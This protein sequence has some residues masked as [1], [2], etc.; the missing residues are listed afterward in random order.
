MFVYVSGGW[1]IVSNEYAMLNEEDFWNE[2][3][4]ESYDIDELEENL[5]S[6]LEKELLAMEFLNKEREQIGNPEN[7]GNVIMGVVWDQFLQQIASSVGDDFIKEN[8]GLT[9]DLRSEAHIQTTENFAKGKIAK[10]NTKTNYQERYDNWQSNLKKDE[11]GNVMTHKTRS[12]RTEATLNKGARKAFDEGRPSGSAERKTDMDHTVSAGEIIRDPAANAH[13]DK[14]EQIAFANSAANLNEMDSSWNR[15]KGD[16][17]MKEWLDNPNAN[18]QKPSEVHNMSK[19]DEQELRKKD[20]E[21]RKEYEKV[22][23]EGEK[24]SIESGKQSQIEETIRAGSKMIQTLVKTLLAQFAKKFFLAL[25][26]WLKSAKKSWNILWEKISNALHSFTDELKKEL[27]TA[28]KNV[29]NLTA[30][31]IIGPIFDTLQSIW[32]TLKQFWKSL[33]EAFAYLN[34]PTNKGK[35]I[36]IMMMEIGKIIIA[37]LTGAGAIGLGALIETALHPLLGPFANIIGIFL[38]AVI[39]GVIGA[40][41]INAIDKIISKKLEKETLE[42]KHKKANEILN[43]QHQVQF[44]RQEKLDRLE[45][46]VKHSISERHQ[47]AANEME[48]SVESIRLNC[49]IDGSIQDALDDINS[50]F[51]ELED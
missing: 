29:V 21:A 26:Q 39:S 9:L 15:S 24:R 10:H 8:G 13:L 49:E 31:M 30:K 23:K 1:N 38:G 37:G 48:K 42:A 2:E 28:S 5:Q 27:I 16:T 36:G 32:N 25:V 18:G 41:A 20:E 45:S 22:K 47:L 34:D 50:L 33:K 4:Y 51:D 17:P 12:G 19:K 6:K 46:D 43:L 44:V 35:S 3:F 40:I 14:N 11:N 7:L